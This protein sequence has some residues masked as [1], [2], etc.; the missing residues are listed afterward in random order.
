MLILWID[1]L[2]ALLNLERI[3]QIGSIHLFQTPQFLQSPLSVRT[4]IQ[5]HWVIPDR[6]HV[7]L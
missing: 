1:L 2:E 7:R 4:T 3:G 5:N 6:D